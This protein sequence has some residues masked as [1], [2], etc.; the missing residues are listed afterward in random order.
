MT[1]TTIAADI[2]QAL[3]VLANL[4]TEVALDEDA[5]VDVVTNA[6]DLVLGEILATGVGLTPVS[7][8]IFVAVVRPIP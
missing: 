3:D 5:A 8:Q 1:Q 7:A 6:R 4:T 2:H